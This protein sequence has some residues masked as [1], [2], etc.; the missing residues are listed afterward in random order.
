M[1]KLILWIVALAT[2]SGSALFGQDLAGTWQGTLSTPAAQLRIVA[3]ITRAAD[4]K[5]EGQLFSI[6]QGGQP[7]PMN[8]ISLDGRTVNWKVDALSASYQG[9]FMAD[10]NAINGTMTQATTS[11]PLNMVRATP[12]TAWAIPEPPPPPKPMDP[13][14]DP[15]IEVATVKLIQVETRGRGLGFQGTQL[16]VNNYSLLNAITFAYDLHE[17]QVSGGPAWMSTD[18]FEIVVKPDTPGQPNPQQIRR[19]LQKVLAERFQLK[20]HSEKR[21][22]S[23]YVITLPANTKHKMTESASG[24]NLPT[25]RFPRPGLLPARNATMAG[26]AQ[27]LQGAVLDR[28]VIDQT[29]IEGRYDFTLDWTPDEFQFASFGPVSQ[30][31]DTGKPNIFQA[32]QEQLGLKLEA[33]KAPADVIVIDKAEKPMEN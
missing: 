6:D 11:M 15:G 22:L 10:G 30:L 28:P 19:L 3:K 16:R 26:L 1:K 24:G 13:A 8:L 23:V 31:P 17:R 33:T 29:K 9:N 20:F 25:L 5:F 4:G 14:A 27:A 21:E 2:L 12:Q 18:R 7:R 32:F